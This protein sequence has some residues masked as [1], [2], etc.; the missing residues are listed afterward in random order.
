M[1]QFNKKALLLCMVL[2]PQ[3]ASGEM[4]LSEKKDVAVYIAQSDSLA[5]FFEK[6][7]AKLN[8][9]IVVSK[10]AAKKKI[11]GEFNLSNPEKMLESVSSLVGLIWYKDGNA[12]Y[13]YDSSELISKVILL[14]NISTNYLVQYMK[15]ANL[16]DDRYPIRGNFNEKTFYISGPPALVELI[17]NTASLLD[18][19]VSSIGAEKVNFG[20]IKLKNTFV[21]DRTYD[22]RGKSIVIPGVATVVEN[23][24]NNNV[25]PKDGSKRVDPMPPFGKT[26]KAFDTIDELSLTTVANNALLD[27]V[28]IIAYPETNSILVKGNDQQIQII[29]DI[30]TQLDVAKRHIELSLWIIDIDKSELNNIGVN[31]Q[32][33]ASFG[34]SFSATFNASSSAS[35]STLDG[36]KFIASVMALNQKK[37]ANVVSR[38]VILTQ[39]NIPAVFDNNRTFYVSLVG[40]RNSS[41]EHVTYGTLINVIPRFSS[42]GQIE[43][44]LT[45]E[46]G[47]GN[48]KPLSI[49]NNDNVSVLPEVGR[50]KISTI[51]R[52]PQGKSLLIGG[53][54]H[55]TDSD[56]VT[57]IPLLSSI[58]VVGNIF[59]YKKNNVSNIVRVFLIQPR[60]VSESNYYD[61]ENYKP[62]LNQNEVMAAT[63]AA[64]NSGEGVILN[65]DQSLISFLDK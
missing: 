4:N 43:M 1:G 22:L 9:P 5:A 64:N 45:I 20:V 58:P 27:N 15:D 40:E 59:R 39:E 52:V 48:N 57:S 42:H 55:D 26:K 2:L 13:I 54:T 53:Y 36:N 37:K 10:Q 24:L 51:A 33:T 17:A 60:E 3:I 56:E 6:F 49:Y 23:L 29:R 46:D 44:S 31:W 28:S 11:T 63:K 47:T 7:S 12:L 21:S 18:R 32:G 61:T 35:I 16:Y 41:L 38:P 8:Y 19:Q 50:T 62:L 14:E 34:D 30:V 25:S 65:D